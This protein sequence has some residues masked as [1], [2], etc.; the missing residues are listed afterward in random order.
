MNSADPGIAIVEQ[1]FGVGRDQ[2]LVGRGRKGR[3]ARVEHVDRLDENLG[4]FQQIGADRGAKGGALGL[5][6][7]G[8]VKCSGGPGGERCGKGEGGK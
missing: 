4:V 6:H 1:G 3:L 7:G 5:G 8:G 2:L